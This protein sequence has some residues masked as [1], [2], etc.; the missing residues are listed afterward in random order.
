MNEPLSN[1]SFEAMEAALTDWISRNALTDE[2][3]TRNV[4][5]FVDA[6]S[7]SPSLEAAIDGLLDNQLD[8][9]TVRDYLFESLGPQFAELSDDHLRRYGLLSVACQF[10]F[11]GWYSRGAVEDAEQLKRLVSE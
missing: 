8:L 3:Q 2:D 4:M 9:S 6:T 7:K 10:F 5:W 1:P 11:V